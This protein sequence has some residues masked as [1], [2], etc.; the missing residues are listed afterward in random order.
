MGPALGWLLSAI[1]VL[2][3][4]IFPAQM[5]DPELIRGSPGVGPISMCDMP[6]LMAE[7]D[8]S[9]RSE[10]TAWLDRLETTG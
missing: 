3:W 7:H 9:H 1:G 8:D 10:I 6:S 5:N 2:I 4:H